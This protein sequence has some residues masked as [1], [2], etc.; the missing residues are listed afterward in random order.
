MER[1][2]VGIWAWIRWIRRV[3]AVYQLR[4]TWILYI[5]AGHLLLET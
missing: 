1:G 3:E 2:E 4:V 5:M